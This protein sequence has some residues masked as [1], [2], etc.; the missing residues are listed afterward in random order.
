MK[1]DKYESFCLFNILSTIRLEWKLIERKLA[2]LF[3]MVCDVFDVE[4]NHMLDMYL[5]YVIVCSGYYLQIEFHQNK[6]IK[7][8]INW[9]LNNH[10]AI[11]CWCIVIP[12][13]SGSH[14]YWKQ[15][16][17]NN[18]TSLLDSKHYISLF[19]IY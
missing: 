6:S 9:I 11:W 8:L 4:I 18:K 12:G 14:P 7:I 13:W 1:I 15:S 16:S 10:N 17:T 2:L 19:S 5:M 3:N